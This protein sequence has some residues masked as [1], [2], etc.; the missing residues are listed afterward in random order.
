MLLAA[1]RSILEF[2]FSMTRSSISI[3][4]RPMTRVMLASKSSTVALTLSNF[5]LDFTRPQRKQSRSEILHDLGDQ[6]INPK[7]KINCSHIEATVSRSVQ[8]RRRFVAIE[9]RRNYGLPIS[10]RYRGAKTSAIL[11]GF[12]FT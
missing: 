2:Q 5:T 7:R 10:V 6:S 8:Y 4:L 12:I 1:T 11:T 9:C 3:G